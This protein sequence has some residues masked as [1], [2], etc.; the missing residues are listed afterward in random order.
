MPRKE[1]TRV[2][3]RTADK[4]FARLLWVHNNQPNEMLLGAFG[5]DGHPA[6]IT[7]EF[8][9]W[10]HAKEEQREIKFLYEDA[11]PVHL[12]IDHFTCHADGRFHA[13]TPESDVLYSQVEHLGEAIGPNS[14]PFLRVLV[15]SDRLSRYASITGVPKK[16]RV[17]FQAHPASILAMNLVFSGINYPLE[18]NALATIASRGQEAAGTILVSGTLKGVVWGN[19]RQMSDEGVVTRPP[20]TILAFS[21]PRG[22]G[23]W[24]IKAFILN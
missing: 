22:V 19:P 7:H 23:S 4:Q 18:H 17:W 8:P 9:E 13:K 21:W 12:K 11:S 24:G 15:V 14:L 2:Y 6:I 16:P 5:L 10:V 3:V 1:P 20:G